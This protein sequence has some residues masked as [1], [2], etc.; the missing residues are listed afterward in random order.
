MLLSD[1]SLSV[2][3]ASFSV[4]LYLH[5]FGSFLAHLC[6]LHSLSGACLWNM[7]TQSVPF[8]MLNSVHMSFLVFPSTVHIHNLD[9]QGL[10]QAFLHLA[11]QRH[12]NERQIQVCMCVCVCV[13]EG[14][15]LWQ[16]EIL[17]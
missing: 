16:H 5:N 2:P 14:G 13:C 10:E 8:I 7:N 6:F 4:T 12:T 17:L 15:S 1:L 11:T 3:F 9:D